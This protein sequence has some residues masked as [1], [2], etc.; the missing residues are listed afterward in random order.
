MEFKERLFQ[1]FSLLF[2]F[3]VFGGFFF[4]VFLGIF[5]TLNQVPADNPIS[6][7]VSGKAPEPSVTEFNQ[8][9]DFNHN[10][11]VSSPFRPVVP[12]LSK[13]RRI[14][15]LKQETCNKWTR[16]FNRSHTE[17]ARSNMNVSCRDAED[18]ARRYLNKTPEQPNY[19]AGVIRDSKPVSSPARVVSN[20]GQCSSWRSQLENI[21]SQLRAGYTEPRGNYLRKRRREISALIYDNCR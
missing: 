2:G 21:Q 20:S 7:P 8:Q 17:I 5:N 11:S 18:Y 13:E 9:V 10:T 4:I 3:L 6:K 19:V 1:V 16:D 14:Y 12:D 15:R